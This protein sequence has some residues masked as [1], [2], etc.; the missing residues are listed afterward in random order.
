V[1]LLWSEGFLVGL[2]AHGITIRRGTITRSDASSQA[3]WPNRSGEEIAAWRAS[4]NTMERWLTEIAPKRARVDIIVS[5]HF[6]RQAVL[7]WSLEL[8]EDDEWLA[9]AKAHIDVTWG[10]AESWDVRIDRLRF[11]S[12]C[13]ACGISQDLRTQLLE[14]QKKSPGLR[15]RSIQPNFTATFNSVAA[16]VGDTATLIAVAERSSVTIGALDGGAWRHVRTLPV[17]DD[18]ADKIERLVNR[19]RLLL[20]LPSEASA[21]YRLRTDTPDYIAAV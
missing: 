4:V 15:V 16:T 11:G 14:L 7:P 17:A 1:S 10:N 12:T 5:D 19:E 3:Y 2:W 8:T 20:G 9:L 13:L 21:I 6:V 18:D